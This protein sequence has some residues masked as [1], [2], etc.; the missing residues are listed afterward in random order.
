MATGKSTR[1]AVAKRTALK[2]PLVKGAAV[3]RTATKRSPVKRSASVT[4]AIQANLERVYTAFHDPRLRE[5]WLPG[6]PMQVEQSTDGKSM[7]VTWTLGNS[8]VDVSFRA[9]GPN[10]S[11]V[12][13][14]HSKLSGAEAV[15]AQKAY[16]DAGLERLNAWLATARPQ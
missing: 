16:W 8:R 1:K 4:R 9:E 6:A 3:K 15:A 10:V 7:T 13:V 2:R 14:Q 5:I 12:E 11:A